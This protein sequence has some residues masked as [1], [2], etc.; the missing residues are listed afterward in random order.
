[1]IIINKINETYIHVSCDEK[2]ALEINNNFQFFGKGY[3]YDWRFKNKHWD[4]K[5]RLF[6]VN[7]KTLFTGLLQDLEDFLNKKRYLYQINFNNNQI[8][9][10]RFEANEFLKTLNL[11]LK[12][13]DFQLDTFI[14]CV[15]LKRNINLLA[16]S[17]GKSLIQYIL[18]QFYKNKKILIIVPQKNL[19]NQ[20]T[21]DF[22]SY[23]GDVDEISK[24]YGGENKFNLKRVVISTFQS[25][26]NIEDLKKWLLQFEVIIC[27]E[28]HRA[29]SES[30]MSI[31]KLAEKCEYRFGFT[32]TIGKAK[33]NE[34]VL[35]GLFGPIKRLISA[36]ELMDTGRAADLRIKI[37]ELIHKK[38][39]SIYLVEKI[40]NLDKKEKYDFE[41][42]QV[43][44]NNIRNR[45]ISNLAL[46]LLGNTLILFRFI[47]HGNNIF[48]KI[49][50]KMNGNTRKVFYIDGSIDGEYRDNIRNIVEN[51]NDAIIV[52]SIK[53]FATGTNIKRLNNIIAAHPMKDDVD[54]LQSIGRSLRLADDKSFSTFYDIADNYIY[55]NNINYGIKHLNIRQDTYRREKFNYKKYRIGLDTSNDR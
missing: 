17:A 38:S 15:Q 43:V 1:M 52:A 10:S 44:N 41:I 29:T 19:V 16:T 47:D 53:T 54:L 28:V 35:T 14:R 36:K 12:P 8:S 13:H 2:I 4:G 55:E 40:N 25:I 31:M 34:M 7:K 3:Q 21:G 37:L 27:D 30:L 45:F 11:P 51:E 48:N 6:S 26:I 49:K 24:I 33:I 23:G 50:E 39:D 18:C 22:I 9:F 46:S 5:V 42:V 32:G 20:M